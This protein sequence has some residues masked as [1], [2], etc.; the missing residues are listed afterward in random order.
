MVK[1]T[2]ELFEKLSTEIGK[3]TDTTRTINS[4]SDPELKEYIKTCNN[5]VVN[6]VN[7]GA[8]AAASGA[9]L[10]AVSATI[11]SAVA[12]GG[13]AIGIGTGVAIGGAS[14][15]AAGGIGAAAGSAVPIIGT[16]IGG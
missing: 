13:S 2:L 6:N 5:V 8:I 14:A 11:G 15:V 10:A 3:S 1:P 9:G 4:I 12:A 7:V 16:I